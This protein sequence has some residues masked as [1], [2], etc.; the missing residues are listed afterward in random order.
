MSTNTITFTQYVFTF[1]VLICGVGFAVWWEYYGFITTPMQLPPVEKNYP[2]CPLKGQVRRICAPPPNCMSTCKQEVSTCTGFCSINGCGCPISKVLNNHRN[3]CISLSQCPAL[4]RYPPCN[5]FTRP[6]CQVLSSVFTHYAEFH[7]Q[8]VTQQREGRFL[9]YVCNSRCG[10]YGNRIQGI[11]VALMLAILSNRTLLIEMKHQIDIN[12][13]LHPNAIQWNYVPTTINSSQHVALIDWGNLQNNWATFSEALYDLNTDMI[14]VGTNLG[15]FWYFRVF[16]DKWTKQ[17]HDAFGISQNYN[18]FSYGCVSKYLFTYDKR[19]TDAIDK[20][21]QELQLIPGKYVSA[22][23]RTQA[24]AGDARLKDQINPLPYFRCG[25]MIASVL[26][27]SYQVYFISDFEEVDKMVTDIYDGK[28][29]TSNVTKM[30][31][32][33]SD[34]LHLSMDSLIEGFIGVLVNIEVAAKGAVFI[35]SGSTMA[36]LI[37]SIGQ[38]SKCSV[39]RGFLI[40]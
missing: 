30:H 7:K 19:V 24:I 28:I 32:D 1:A 36:D 26:G 6:S 20:E 2:P 4:C 40:Y 35:R 38:F 8:V 23:Y 31:I 39:V 33:R 18:V 25:V 9:K 15:F 5:D 10:G 37:E 27:K 34:V 22:H 16:N 11:T 29:V 21:I 3:E 17:F 13:L 12:I 14:T